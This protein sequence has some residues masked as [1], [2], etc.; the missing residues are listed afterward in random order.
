M[1]KLS[2]H[3]SF[4]DSLEASIR[5]QLLT[6]FNEQATW[7]DNCNE[8]STEDFGE[9]MDGFDFAACQRPDGSVYGIASGANCRKGSP[10][11]VRPGDKHRDIMRKGQRAGLKVRSI[12]EENDRLRADKGVKVV[13]GEK[14]IQ[15]LAR[16]LNQR[17]GHGQKPA[18]VK[19]VKSADDAVKNTSSQALR[20]LVKAGDRQDAR[21]AQSAANRLQAARKAKGADALIKPRPPEQEGFLKMGVALARKN[22]DPAKIKEAMDDLREFRKQQRMIKGAARPAA[23]PIQAPGADKSVL[24]RKILEEEKRMRRMREVNDRAGLRE[25]ARKAAKAAKPEAEK[26]SQQVNKKF[27]R[28][29]TTQKLQ[30]YLD[31]RKLFPYQRK[32]IEAELAK[33]A[34]AGKG[35]EPKPSV[36]PDLR[37]Q[38]K[39]RK[40]AIDDIDKQI[41]QIG[42]ARQYPIYQQ[43]ANKAFLDSVEKGLIRRRGD[44]IASK[45]PVAG[46]STE[47]RAL[48]RKPATAGPKPYGLDKDLGVIVNKKLLGQDTAV[49]QRILQERSLN[50]RQRAKIAEE[51]VGRG[52]SP[53][54][55][56]RPGPGAAKT[57]GAAAKAGWTVTQAVKDYDPVAVFNN[58]SNTLIGKGGMGQAFR[59]DGPPPGIIKRGKIGEHEVE[60]WQK[61]QGT[62]RVPEI[63]GAAVSKGMKEIGAGYGG[64]VR[65]A[66]GYL[67]LGMAKGQTVS[68]LNRQGN[69]DRDTRQNVVNEYIR[70][71]KDIHLAGVA[72]NDM[73]AQNIFYDRTTGKAQLID[74][75]LAQPTYKAALMEALNTN[76]GDWQA[77][78]FLRSYKQSGDSPEALARLSANQARVATKMQREGIDINKVYDMGIRNK[79]EHIDRVLNNMSEAAAEAYLKVLYDGV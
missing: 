60:V 48:I 73:H 45:A 47:V 13:R 62:G 52:E 38:V 25:K 23:K 65:E 66:N 55:G 63:H 41:A 5:E 78:R 57:V 43:T 64:H 7:A 21:A 16:R 77:E 33:R 71:R 14:A 8:W 44:I 61:L 74:F 3:G 51:V 10:I 28:E 76:R 2:Q 22:G 15:S 29:R 58:P 35:V 40:A 39:A 42:A 17:M 19:G 70:A 12:L 69:P 24:R 37:A 49:L 34:Q 18:D 26:P 1:T 75:G 6:E 53:A 27:L 67:G 68:S 31:N 59:T 36:K 9:V 30:A 11:S 54:S 56:R 50:P 72:H 20:D 32:A 79:P 4:D 46:S